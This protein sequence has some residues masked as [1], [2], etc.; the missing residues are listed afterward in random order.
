[1]PLEQWLTLNLGRR[2]RATPEAFH[3][4][5][6]N[7]HH[8]RTQALSGSCCDILASHPTASLDS[9]NSA[10]LH[11]STCLTSSIS[12]QPTAHHHATAVLIDALT[13]PLLFLERRDEMGFPPH[14]QVEE[15][16]K[17]GYGLTRG[18]HERKARIFVGL[19]QEKKGGMN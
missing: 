13:N 18:A 3:R 6:V 17:T 8:P 2:I 4:L 11:S 10:L 16:F 5:S 15:P 9:Q 7:D 19:R 14:V 12:A 1:M